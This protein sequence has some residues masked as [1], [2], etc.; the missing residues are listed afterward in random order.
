[1]IDTVIVF[2]IERGRKRYESC[3]DLL[4]EAGVPEASILIWKGIDEQDFTDKTE[5][6]KHFQRPV[7]AEY[8]EFSPKSHIAQS[9]SYLDVLIYLQEQKKTGLIIFD[10]HAIYKRKYS[11][12]LEKLDE[13]VAEDFYMVSISKPK[14]FETFDNYKYLRFEKETWW[15]TP[16][17]TRTTMRGL[18][19]PSESGLIL[20]PTGASLFADLFIDSTFKRINLKI[21]TFE[22]TLC[23][24]MA[25]INSE[26]GEHLYSFSDRYVKLHHDRWIMPLIQ[27]GDA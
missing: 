16:V 8:V 23:R 3:K 21:T 2:S 4:L 13:E 15:Q 22:L 19:T 10:D 6:A 7:S 27:S 26:W 17:G 9:I 1:M 12:I 18:Q 24:N 14:M 20:S 11:E 25:W 5:L